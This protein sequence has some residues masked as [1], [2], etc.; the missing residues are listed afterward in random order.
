MGWRAKVFALD[1]KSEQMRTTSRC[2]SHDIPSKFIIKKFGLAQ[3]ADG[4]AVLLSGG[5]VRLFLKKQT[6]TPDTGT[7]RMRICDLH[8]SLVAQL[9]LE[10]VGGRVR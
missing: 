1:Q 9:R 3:S 7:T 8:H 6:I 4:F 10:I 2:I 5:D